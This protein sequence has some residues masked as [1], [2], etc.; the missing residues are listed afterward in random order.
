MY[1]SIRIPSPYRSRYVNK[2]RE[3]K[4]LLTRMAPLLLAVGLPGLAAVALPA[5]FD[6]LVPDLPEPDDFKDAAEGDNGEEEEDSD[7]E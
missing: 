5:V 6:I 3:L 1:G 7:E 2:I 4:S